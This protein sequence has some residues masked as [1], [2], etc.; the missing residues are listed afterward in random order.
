MVWWLSA[1]V[2]MSTQARIR[3]VPI[4]EAVLIAC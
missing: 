2:Q 1:R 3:L 4:V